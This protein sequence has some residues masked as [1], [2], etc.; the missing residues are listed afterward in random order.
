MGNTK[1]TSSKGKWQKVVGNCSEPMYSSREFSLSTA[2]ALLVGSWATLSLDLFFRH[3]DFYMETASRLK[4]PKIS[5]HLAPPR[6]CDCCNFLSEGFDFFIDFQPLAL[7]QFLM[8][9]AANCPFSSLV[10]MRA[11]E[12]Q[13]SCP[14]V[15]LHSLTCSRFLDVH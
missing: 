15:C 11:H 14:L 3:R 10:K 8:N 7:S 13:H 9:V 4:L 12:S 1:K 5:I 6:I 2:Q